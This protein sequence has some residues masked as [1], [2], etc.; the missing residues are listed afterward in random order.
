MAEHTGYVPRLDLWLVV[1]TVEGQVVRIDLEPE[2]RATGDH[3]LLERVLAHLDGDL[4]P[5][6][7][8]PVALGDL[9]PFR[10]RALEALRDVPPGETVTY[11]GLAERVGSPGG[12]RA[13]GG[14]VRANPVPVVVPCHRV[15]AADGLGGYSGGRG[16]STKR[17]LLEIE[18]AYSPSTTSTG[19]RNRISSPSDGA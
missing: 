14:A 13:V 18:G 4:D 10:R 8:V 12:A 11:G 9:P 3:P 1:E 7:D 2:G 15:V 19:G 5:L 17:R 6:R 16:P